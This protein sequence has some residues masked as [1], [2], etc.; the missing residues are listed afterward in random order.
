MLLRNIT[1]HCESFISKHFE[2][3]E[4]DIEIHRYDFNDICMWWKQWL[5]LTTSGV[6]WKYNTW[7]SSIKAGSPYL[8]IFDV[9][10]ED[11]SFSQDAC[12]QISQYF[13]QNNLKLGKYFII[14]LLKF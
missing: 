3:S 7:N 12:V 14:I 2:T 11:Y 13:T 1:W 4:V 10:M 8:S 5:E 6:T 9:F